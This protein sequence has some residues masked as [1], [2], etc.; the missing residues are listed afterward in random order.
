MKKL[1]FKCLRHMHG[2][3]AYGPGDKRELSAVDAGPLVRSGAIEPADKE[4]EKAMMELLSKPAAN[5]VASN[6]KMDANNARAAA[7]GVSPVPAKSGQA[8][9][10]K[11]AGNAERN[12]ADV[13]PVQTGA[14]V[15]AGEPGVEP[16]QP[17]DAEDEKKPAAKE[18]AK[19]AAP[20]KAKKA[21]AK[22]SA[23][24]K[25]R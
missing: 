23:R 7:E 8:V 19:T 18:P 13:S 11:D 25:K 9:A 1:K 21:P 22:K 16:V 5:P 10:G 12:K 17:E 15:H 4:A 2:D 14:A 6:R 3:R 24:K 20:A